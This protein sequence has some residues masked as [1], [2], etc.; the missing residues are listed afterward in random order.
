MYRRFFPSVLYLHVSEQQN[1]GIS[2]IGRMISNP[3]TL[4]TSHED[5]WCFYDT[6]INVF[7]ER[8]TA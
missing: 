2:F 8:I 7:V 3:L 4:V 5:S 1:T 6:T